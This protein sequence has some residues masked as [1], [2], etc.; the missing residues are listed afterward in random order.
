MSSSLDEYALRFLTAIAMQNITSNRT[1]GAKPDGEMEEH[2]ENPFLLNRPTG[3]GPGLLNSGRN[4]PAGAQADEQMVGHT[5][6]L[7]NTGQ[8]SIT[9]NRTAGAQPDGEMEENR[10]GPVLQNPRRNIPADAQ[11]DGELMELREGPVLL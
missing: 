3:C 2:R 5:S 6:G 11:A 1:A 7:Q 10:E 8:R 4:I 9:R